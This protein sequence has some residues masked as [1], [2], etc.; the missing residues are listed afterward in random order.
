MNS[1][2][3]IASYTDSLQANIIKGRLEAESIPATLANEQYIN[4]DWL[5][6]NALGGVQLQVPADY[7]QAAKAILESID[8]GDLAITD[9]EET[10]QLTCPLCQ[11]DD[12]KTRKWLWRFSFIALNFFHLPLPFSQHAYHCNHC[13]HQW[14]D[15]TES[16]YASSTILLYILLIATIVFSVAT[17]ITMLIA[18]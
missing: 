3:T 10:A 17:V 16:E 2:V 18:E 9:D 4:A 15:E 11:S 8:A 1:L 14:S 7:E 13:Q 12:I 5:L 6:S